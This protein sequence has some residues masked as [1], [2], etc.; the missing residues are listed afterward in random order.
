MTRLF[1][2]LGVFVRQLDDE[3]REVSQEAEATWL[4]HG[5]ATGMIGAASDVD[6]AAYFEYKSTKYIGTKL[7]T[8]VHAA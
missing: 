4:A 1:L 3:K 7:G 5:N 2:R 6:Y 8:R